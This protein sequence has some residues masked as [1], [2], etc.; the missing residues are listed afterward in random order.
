L[1]THHK[2]DHAF[3]PGVPT[4]LSFFVCSLPRSGSSLLCELLTNTELAGAPTEYFD[5]ELMNEF[6]RA[7]G[8]ETLDDYLAA[9][10]AKKTS[11][12]GVFGCKFHLHQLRATFGDADVREIFPAL[13]CV[14]IS[15]RDHVRQA[16]SYAR[17]IETNQWASDHAAREVQPVFDREQIDRLKAQIEREEAQWQRFFERLHMTPFAVVYE[18][19]VQSIEATVFSVI[20]F[21]GIGAPSDLRL[22]PPTLQR[23]ADALSEEWVQ[24]YAAG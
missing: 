19:F 15:R 6:R 13:R 8:V 23:Q 17:A 16:V 11:P 3:P 5:E 20:D 24:R 1:Y 22:D 10:L 4:C 12:N 14:F 2:I 7:W 18:D 9:L 21:L